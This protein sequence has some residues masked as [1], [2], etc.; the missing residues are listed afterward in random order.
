MEFAGREYIYLPQKK[1]NKLNEYKY[2]IKMEI[3]EENQNEAP[4]PQINLEK[5]GL[6]IKEDK[7]EVPLPSLLDPN[8]KPKE[9]QDEENLNLILDNKKEIEDE[10]ISCDSNSFCNISNKHLND[11]Y[12]N[13]WF[14]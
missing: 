13:R 9:N 6:E 14:I 2:G 10:N 1:I 11:I 5:K 4:L 8:K 12:S 7:K 3:E